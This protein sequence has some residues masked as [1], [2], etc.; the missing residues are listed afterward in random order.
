M[1]S[2]AP[3]DVVMSDW[4]IVVI[5]HNGNII[6]KFLGY[7]VRDRTYRISSQIQ[8]YDAE[9][10]TGTTLSGSSYTFLDPPGQLHPVAQPVFDMLD[11]RDDVEITLKFAWDDES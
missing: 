8:D 1:E 11:K 6:E 3:A 2:L 10:K 4:N 5:K 9:D 7:S